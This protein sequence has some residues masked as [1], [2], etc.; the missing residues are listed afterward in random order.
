MHRAFRPTLWTPRRYLLF[1]FITFAS[2]HHHSHT[3]RWTI[4]IGN[5]F[6][7]N[8]VTGDGGTRDC[9]ALIQT[10]KWPRAS[11]KMSRKYIRRIRNTIKGRAPITIRVDR[12]LR[13]INN[14]R[15]VNTA[16]RISHSNFHSTKVIFTLLHI[17]TPV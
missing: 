1:M 10:E 2:H 17:Q 16:L 7:D 6:A 12:V 14:P 11:C 5:I 8:T 9:T 3:L 4:E 15:S 13:G